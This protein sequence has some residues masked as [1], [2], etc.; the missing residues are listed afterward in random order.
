MNGCRIPNNLNSSDA[1]TV[2]FSGVSVQ[3]RAITMWWLVEIVKCVTLTLFPLLEENEWKYHTYQE[4]PYISNKGGLLSA[5]YFNEVEK[6]NLVLHHEVQGPPSR[7]PSWRRN[8]RGQRGW[9]RSQGEIPGFGMGWIVP[10]LW[11]INEKRLANVANELRKRKNQHIKSNYS[12]LWP[13]NGVMWLLC[14]CTGKHPDGELDA[15]K[16]TQLWLPANDLLSPTT[17]PIC[18]LEDF[19]NTPGFAQSMDDRNSSR[20]QGIEYLCSC[21]SRWFGNLSYFLIEWFHLRLIY[22]H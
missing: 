10:I 2:P 18:L 20:C 11:F 16:K 12:L 22:L 17:L 1:H 5:I 15:W 7:K 8:L 3:V 9:W 6:W 4:S 14:T 21:F 19:Q 13:L